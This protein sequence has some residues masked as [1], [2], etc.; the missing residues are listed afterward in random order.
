VFAGRVHNYQR[1]RPLRFLAK[2]APGRTFKAGPMCAVDGDFELD[3]TFDGTTDTTPDGVLYIVTGAR[4]AGAYDPDQTDNQPTW[5][6]YT[7]KL[8]GDICSFTGVELDRI[9]VTKPSRLRGQERPD[10][11]RP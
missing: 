4:G 5:Q 11:H 7:A 3:R 8:V 1:T 2:P 10:Q 6:E 9:V